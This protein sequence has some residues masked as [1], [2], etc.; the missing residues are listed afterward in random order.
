MET[1]AFAMARG[2][3]IESDGARW[4]SALRSR[5][6]S[7]ASTGGALGQRNPTIA[8]TRGDIRG[9][10]RQSSLDGARVVQFAAGADK[11]SSLR[12]E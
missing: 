11:L 2:V 4:L 8:I 5:L 6:I 10:G 12:S 9:N 1:L 3:A 7:V